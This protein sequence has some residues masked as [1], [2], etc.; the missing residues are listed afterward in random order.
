MMRL[1]QLSVVISA[2]IAIAGYYVSPNIHWI[3]YIFKPLTTVL[4]LV[5]ALSAITETKRYKIAIVAGLICSLAGDVFLML[6]GDQFLPGLVSF[7]LAHVCYLIAF[8]TDAPLM[9][10]KSPYF[11]M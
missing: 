1:L 9:A 6:P 11:F 7:L 4:I 2:L 5:L 10:R 3:V 8:T